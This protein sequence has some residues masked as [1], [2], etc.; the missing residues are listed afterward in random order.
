MCNRR[1]QIVQIVLLTVTTVEASGQQSLPGRTEEA[2]LDSLINLGLRSGRAHA[3]LTALTNAA[4]HRLSGSPGAAAA[5]ELTHQLMIDLG[6]DRVHREEVMVP[7]WI[8]GGV[9]K[10][11]IIN[12]RTLGTVPLPACALGGSIGT[13]PLGIVAGVVEVRSFEQ[14]RALGSRAE[15]KIV[16]FNRPF[17]PTKLDTFDGYSGAVDQRVRGTI[18]AAKVGAVASLVRSIATAHDDVPHTGNMRYEEGTNKI[19]SAA[20]SVAAATLLSDLLNREPDL[21]IRLELSCT[22][23]PDVPSAN[24]MGELTGSEF[25]QEVILVGGHLDAWDKGS[26]AHD[27]GSGCV[28]AIEALRLL[29]TAGIKPKKTIRAVLFI[30]E[31]NGL[32][33]GKAYPVSPMRQGEYHLA[34]IESDRGGFAPRGL[35]IES[36]STFLA[37]IIRWRPL[38]ERI[39][40]GHIVAGGSGVDISPLVE[41]GT[42]GIGL[43]PESSRYFDYHHSDNDTIDKVNARELE[44]GAIVEAL[45]C[46]QLSEQGL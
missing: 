17:D 35:T 7:R 26:G 28:Q 21:S 6:F 27:D 1:I 46:Y 45:L 3:M 13:P 19:P 5:I 22:T 36:D 15:G 31:E 32:R 2:I 18:E 24:V 8:R 44:M 14:L 25:P 40:A 23:L 11:T 20:L 12:S 4:P 30:N 9:E 41:R 43:F 42:P 34:A 39:G 10:A 29:K 37:K 33:G 38:F 16:F